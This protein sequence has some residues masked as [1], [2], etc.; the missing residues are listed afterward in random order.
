MFNVNLNNNGTFC[1]SVCRHEFVSLLLNCLIEFVQ[2]L[3]D[4]LDFPGELW[5]L[6]SLTRGR[7]HQTQKLK[8]KVSAA[9]IC[10]ERPLIIIP[11]H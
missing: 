4:S 5:R 3:I 9:L 1:L 2:H 11:E 10:C 7:K 6:W 8:L